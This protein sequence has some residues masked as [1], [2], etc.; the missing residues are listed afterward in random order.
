MLYEVIT[1]DVPEAV[2]PPELTRTEVAGFPELSEVDVVRHFSYN[3][4]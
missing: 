4:V 2:L 1:L 3:F